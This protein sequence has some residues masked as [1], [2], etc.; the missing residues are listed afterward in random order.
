M[1]CKYYCGLFIPAQ[2]CVMKKNLLKSSE[3]AARQM[4]HTAECGAYIRQQSISLL[5]LKQN[6]EITHVINHTIR[7]NI[8]FSIYELAR[9][10]LQW[11][12]SESRY[13]LLRLSVIWGRKIINLKEC[14]CILCISLVFCFKPHTLCSVLINLPRSLFSHPPSTS[15]PLRTAPSCDAARSTQGR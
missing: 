10:L 2:L 11:V 4:N 12:S 7:L 14:C 13:R 1:S 5:P 15:V 8:I 9:K 6:T 3:T